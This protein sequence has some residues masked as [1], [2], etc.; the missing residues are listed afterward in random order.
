MLPEPGAVCPLLTLHSF[1]SDAMP[2]GPEVAACGKGPKR[3]DSGGDSWA[4]CS[5]G[6]VGLLG[7]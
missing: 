1:Q 5:K 4:P 6:R 3:G 2:P 7:A